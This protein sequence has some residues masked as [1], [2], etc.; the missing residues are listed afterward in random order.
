MVRK[1]C[2]LRFSVNLNVVVVIILFLLIYHFRQVF[3]EKNSFF[4]SSI[5]EPT[6]KQTNK[7]QELKR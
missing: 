3:I 2:H 7:Q 4:F 6:L 5:C 1:S